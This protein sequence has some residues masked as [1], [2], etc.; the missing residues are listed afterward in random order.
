L[1][2]NPQPGLG[3]SLVL[4]REPDFLIRLYRKAVQGNYVVVFNDR[5]QWVDG[6]YHS[7]LPNVPFLP[8]TGTLVLSSQ[9]DKT[10]HFELPPETYARWGYF[11]LGDDPAIG[12][13][14]FN[15]QWRVTSARRGG[16]SLY[17][18]TQIQQF[19]G[20]YVDRQ[21]VLD[22]VTQFEDRI[23]KLV[24]E[25]STDQRHFMTIA[26]VEPRGSS[27]NPTAY[28][29]LD[30]GIQPDRTY[31]YRLVASATGDPN[32]V[33]TPVIE[34]RTARVPIEFWLDCFPSQALSAQQLNI[35]VY[36]AYSQVVDLRLYD[37]RMAERQRLYSGL[38]YAEEDHILRFRQPLP[39][40]TYHLL[41]RV[42]RKRYHRTFRITGG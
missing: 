23:D 2:K 14:Y 3:R 28:R 12:F 5:L 21:V 9:P 32:P 39:P 27:A 22:W 10:I 18:R 15:G 11:Q 24:V 17:N 6:F 40:G 30:P 26:T 13:E 33:Y 38:V 8:D 29:H 19:Q 34:V 4:S 25:R 42:G 36:S 37:S 1:V 20:R 7:E 41:A 16:A 31:Y 35:S